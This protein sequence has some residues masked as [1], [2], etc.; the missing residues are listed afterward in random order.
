MFLS[1]SRPVLAYFMPNLSYYYSMNTFV[2]QC[3]DA[4]SLV[5][6]CSYWLLVL[7]VKLDLFGYKKFFFFIFLLLSS[8][9]FSMHTLARAYSLWFTYSVCI[10]SHISA[11]PYYIL[12]KLVL[13]LFT[14]RILYKY[15]NFQGKA[16]I[17]TYLTRHFT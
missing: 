10:F 2:V 3:F 4:G 14:L 1:S 15:S 13:L 9:L 11:I 7:L 12:M 17:Q 6:I 8:S 5:L 16:T